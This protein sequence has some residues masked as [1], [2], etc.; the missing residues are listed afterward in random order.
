M[1]NKYRYHLP[2]YRQSKMFAAHQLSIPDNT[3]AGWAMGGAEQLSPLGEA[4]WDQL[5]LTRALQVDETPVKI[6]NPEKKAYMWLYHSYLP[7][8]R[9]VIFDFSLT[10]AA[11]AVNERLATY[12]GL[13][14]TDAYSGY[15]TQRKRKAIVSF[16]CWD[17]ARRKFADVIKAAGNNKS[18]KA[19]KMLEK[20]AKLYDIEKN[21]KSLPADERQSIR[22]Q[23]SAPTLAALRSFLWKINAPPKSL[24]GVAVTYCKNQWDDLVR[25]VDYGDAQIS[26]CWVE[27]QVRPFA[28]GRR[29]WLFVGNE[30]SAKKAA[31]IYSLIQSCELNN[32]DPR[33]YLVYVLNQVHRMR[34][35][36]VNPA[37]LLPNTIDI[38]LL[39]TG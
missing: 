2:F 19:G 20:I 11:S 5:K 38:N 30:N 8:Q 10:R 33:A 3:L 39:E 25:Y 36:E 22:Q 37:V 18:G 15:H 17:H 14:Q 13:L 34:R 23:E 24:L 6:L 21:I 27:N 28:V 32:I 9:F 4:M 1:I 26:N 35:K 12:E 7:G 16:G 29:N 31:L